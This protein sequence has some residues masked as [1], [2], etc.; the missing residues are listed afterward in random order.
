MGKKL[1]VIVLICLLG[2]AIG[3][4][5]KVS[6]VEASDPIG[7]RY[8]PVDTESPPSVVYD[9]VWEPVGGLITVEHNG[10]FQVGRYSFDDNRIV[11][12]DGSTTLFREGGSA[13][14]TVVGSQE[15]EV[16]TI[17]GEEVIADID[18]NEPRF[19]VTRWLVTGHAHFTN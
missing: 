7:D 16:I 10:I 8:C 4:F 3:V 19:R 12:G 11:F 9:E 2:V 17:V 5:L 18:I 15:K 14:P 1:T 13:T 6:L